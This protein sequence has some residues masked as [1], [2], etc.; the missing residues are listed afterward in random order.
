[1]NPCNKS[2]NKEHIFIALPYTTR[3]GKSDGVR[4]VCKYCKKSRVAL[5]KEERHKMIR[6]RFK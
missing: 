3:T 4:V 2:P 1:M 5:T 6:D